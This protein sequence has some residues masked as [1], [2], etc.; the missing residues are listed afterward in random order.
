MLCTSEYNA[1]LTPILVAELLKGPNKRA[2]GSERTALADGI[3]E[4]HGD[5]I[6]D[7]EIG[8]GPPGTIDTTVHPVNGSV[9][10]SGLSDVLCKTV[11]IF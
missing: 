9:G 3:V 1:K 4:L 11:Q 8:R 2:A 6:T 7:P 5:Q 10:T